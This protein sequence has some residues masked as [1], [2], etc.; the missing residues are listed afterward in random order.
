VITVHRDQSDSAPPPPSLEPNP[1]RSL[2]DALKAWKEKLRVIER[3]EAPQA[4][5]HE[6][7]PP[8][9]QKSDTYE[10]LQVHYFSVHSLLRI[11]KTH[12]RRSRDRKRKKRPIRLLG[13]RHRSRPRARRRRERRRHKERRKRRVGRASSAT[14]RRK[15]STSPTPRC[16]VRS[17]L[18]GLH[19][20]NVRLTCKVTSK[21]IGQSKAEKAAE[22]RTAEEPEP[23]AIEEKEVQV[24]GSYRE[25]IVSAGIGHRMAPPSFVL[26]HSRDLRAR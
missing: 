26:L 15:N 13:L 3:R 14:K 19:P 12:A 7:F 10:F 16:S 21:P 24:P 11:G 4:Q 18:V 8:Q 23:M 6:P 25:E 17:Y 2:G 20:A 1:Y 22:K 5:R 9:S